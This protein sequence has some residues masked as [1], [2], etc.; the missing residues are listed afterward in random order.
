MWLGKGRPTEGA[1]KQYRNKMVLWERSDKMLMRLRARDARSSSAFSCA[2]TTVARAAESCAISAPRASYRCTP[3]C[4]LGFRA[5]E[6]VRHE[7]ATLHAR[8]AVASSSAPWRRACPGPPAPPLPAPP[9]PPP[10]RRRQIRTGPS[11]GVRGVPPRF[12]VGFKCPGW[13]VGR[14]RGVLP[15]TV[16]G[17]P[18]NN[19]KNSS[20][21]GCS[22]KEFP[23]F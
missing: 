17:G 13:C 5:P 6:C 21:Q 7:R 12:L 2:G 19:K 16:W 1:A 4:V 10:P 8:A 11:L 9:P 3:R 20:W 14:W 23:P 22:K 18:N 15:P